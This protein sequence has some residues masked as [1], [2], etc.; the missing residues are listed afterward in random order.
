MIHETMFCRIPN[1]EDLAYGELALVGISKCLT[2]PSAAK[3]L[4]DCMSYEGRRSGKLNF[5]SVKQSHNL[6][7]TL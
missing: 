3:V 6:R 4:L 7:L 5:Q 1:V 2:N